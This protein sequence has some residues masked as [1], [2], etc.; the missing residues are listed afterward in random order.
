MVSCLRSGGSLKRRL[1]GCDVI[2]WMGRNECVGRRFGIGRHDT[3]LLYCRSQR[4]GVGAFL[5][6]HSFSAAAVSIAKSYP[7][8]SRLC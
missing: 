4:L 5:F 8:H 2:S 6:R 3:G 1:Q 7:R